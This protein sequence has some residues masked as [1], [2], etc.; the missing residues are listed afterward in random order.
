[1]AHPA[2]P[3][4]SEG[5]ERRRWPRYAYPGEQAAPD[6]SV[7]E[8]PGDTRVEDLCL[9]GIGLLLPAPVEVGQPLTLRLRPPDGGAPIDVGAA[10]VYALP[11][12]AG[13][14]AGAFFSRQLTEE[15]RRRLL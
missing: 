15:E 6:V 4:G 2:D 5:S 1:M 10:V 13:C 9:E 14:R 12:R 7:A 8:V 3:E 11:H